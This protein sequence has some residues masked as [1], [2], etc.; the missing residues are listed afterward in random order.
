ML[1]TWDNVLHHMQEVVLTDTFLAFSNVG[2][3]VVE[4]LPLFICMYVRK[5]LC[6]LMLWLWTF[7]T[8]L[9]WIVTLDG[10]CLVCSCLHIQTSFPINA[11]ELLVIYV[12][13]LIGLRTFTT[14]NK[15]QGTLEKTVIYQI[16]RFMCWLPWIIIWQ[17][18]KEKMWMHISQV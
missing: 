13:P 1:I 2:T 15:S 6:I 3:I 5:K 14:R 12:W 4:F 7:L 8:N 11:D 10:P 17:F 16:R 9:K 18:L